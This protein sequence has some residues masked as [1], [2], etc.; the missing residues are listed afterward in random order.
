MTELKSLLKVNGG[1]L[2]G[3][4]AVIIIFCGITIVNNP[5]KW[6]ITLVAIGVLGLI[7][8]LFLNAMVFVKFLVAFVGTI[9]LSGYA[10]KL[11]TMADD[12]GS[13]G[14]L[15]SLSGLFLFFACWALTSYISSSK[16]K[17]GLIAGA[18]IIFFGLVYILMSISFKPVLAVIFGLI[19]SL[20]YFIMFY[21]F[22]KGNRYKKSEMPIN[23]LTEDFA[24]KVEKT[25][26]DDESMKA[27]G[28]AEKNEGSIVLFKDKAFVL[29]PVMIEQ[30]FGTTGKKKKQTLSYKGKP[31]D[32][33]LLTVFDKEV[34]F[35]GTKNSDIMLVV[36]DI[37]SGNGKEPKVIAV[38]IPDSRKSIPVGVLPGK[39]LLKKKGDVYK[40]INN[41]FGRYIKPLNEKQKKAL[42]GLGYSDT[43]TANETTKKEND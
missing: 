5:S 18:E 40:A 31:I 1:Y 37:S 39:G 35:F 19:V 8:F 34:P 14:P 17:W 3:L 36:F 9:L 41:A 21:K 11:G 13:S 23:I 43:S 42:H 25:L 7:G 22:G 27:F 15:W 32:S 2:T 12:T 30:N 29:Y 26:D 20:C 33:W 6:W 28:D 38:N 10:F 16:A 24:T 4:L